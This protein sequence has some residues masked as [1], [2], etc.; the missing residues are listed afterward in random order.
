MTTEDAVDSSTDP[1]L[2]LLL[3]DRF[4][5]CARRGA[6]AMG[7]V[8]EGLHESLGRKVAV[9]C[10]HPH[11][12]S[13]PSFVT[14]FVKEARIASRVVHPNIVRVFAFGNETTPQG[15]IAYL[16]M[17]FCNGRQLGDLVAQGARFPLVRVSAIMGQVLAA[18]SELHDHGI[19]HRDVKPENVILEP[20]PRG[21]E[22][23]KLIDFGIAEVKMDGPRDAE[24]VAG[25]PGY[26]SP[27]VI[28][29]GAVDHQA[30]LYAAGCMLFELVTGR[31]L[32]DADTVAGLLGQQVDAP[33]PDPRTVAPEREIPDALAEVC[34]RAV[35]LDPA[36]RFQ[37]ADA[38][39]DALV[40]ALAPPARA[41]RSSPLPAA[42]VS[43]RSGRPPMP[44]GPQIRS[45]SPVGRYSYGASEDRPSG[46][47]TRGRETGFGALSELEN[48]ATTAIIKRRW[49]E[50]AD[51]LQRGLDAASLLV[52]GGQVELGGAAV[53]SFGRRLGEALRKDGR[54]AEALVVLRRA[55]ARAQDGGLPR[56]LLLEE[57]GLNAMALGQTADA[58]G[59]WLDGVEAAR[60]CGNRAVE[61]RLLQ[62]IDERRG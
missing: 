21:T 39:S 61:Q 34:L 49:K 14:R 1:R 9:K 42:P 62:R 30:D 8:Y 19:V 12:A 50:A 43:E 22:V 27:E 53:R 7:T 41:V 2:G 15:D 47:H 4:L 17:E 44:S 23:V 58:V 5:L 11:L 20:G 38:F 13:S 40:A 16:V 46:E 59:A 24:G 6:G 3:G 25:T 33:R 56:A 26:L 35:A 31:A 57:L 36:A 28:R 60:A 32:F 45:V 51:A 10:L 18:L 29:G 54:S 48:E 37:D 52:E 55:L